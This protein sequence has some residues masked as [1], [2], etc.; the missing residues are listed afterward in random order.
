MNKLALGNGFVDMARI[1]ER[2]GDRLYLQERACLRNL[3]TT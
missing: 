2:V 1:D 3:A